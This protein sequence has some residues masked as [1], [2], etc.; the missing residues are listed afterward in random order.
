M[1]IENNLGMGKCLNKYFASDL[2]KGNWEFWACGRLANG[3]E[4]KEVEITTS[5]VE[6]KLKQLNRTKLGGLDNLH[7]RILKE[8]A[9]EVA[10]P[11]ARIFNESINSG[12]RP[13]D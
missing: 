6:V 12:V 10:S 3:N 13:Y 9:R 1:E 11:P 2:I 7:P 4:D 5:E 8:L